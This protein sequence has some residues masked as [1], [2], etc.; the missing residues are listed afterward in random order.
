MDIRAGNFVVVQLEWADDAEG[1]VTRLTRETYDAFFAGVDSV[2]K[3]RQS[4]APVGVSADAPAA[5][6]SAGVGP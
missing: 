1:T 5:P 2:L 3:G 4:G 6:S